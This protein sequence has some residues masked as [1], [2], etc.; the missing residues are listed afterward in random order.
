MK[1]KELIVSYENS[2]VKSLEG[3][4]IF[5]HIIGSLAL[6]TVIIGGFLYIVNIGN[7]YSSDEATALLGASLASTFFPLVL[8]S[9]FFGIVCMGLSSIAKTALYKRTILEQQYNFRRW[10]LSMPPVDGSEQ[11][12]DSQVDD[13]NNSTNV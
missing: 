9:F 5:F 1:K 11:N 2:G 4:G 3:F 6:L 13:V 12:I 8:I 10:D 7:S